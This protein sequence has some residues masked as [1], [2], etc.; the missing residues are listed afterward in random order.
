MA[1]RL[2]VAI[3]DHIVTITTFLNIDKI[4]GMSYGGRWD[5]DTIGRRRNIT[6]R[7]A[8]IAL[9]VNKSDGATKMLRC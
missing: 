2:S 7:E 3:L 1:Y 4:V 8:V 9:L 5:A 6:K